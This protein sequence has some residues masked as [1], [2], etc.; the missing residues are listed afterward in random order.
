ML[1]R[2]VQDKQELRFYNW[3]NATAAE[4]DF[5]RGHF[6]LWMASKEGGNSL[7]GTRYTT[8]LFLNITEKEQMIV[9]D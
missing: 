9:P 6:F 2:F 1:I 3:F 7:G 4:I 8:H 5:V